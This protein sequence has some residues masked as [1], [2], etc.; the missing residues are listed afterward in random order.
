M[1]NEQKVPITIG[2]ITVD[3]P[4]DRRTWSGINN[5]LLRA[6]NERVE[7]VIPLGPLRP[8]PLLFL[9]K[10]INQVMLRTTGKRFNYRD[11]FLLSRAYARR[12]DRRLKGVDLLLAPA[13][14]ATTA[15][16]RTKVPVVYVN[17]RCIAGA[18][19]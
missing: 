7:R 19:D 3:D 10:L 5:F 18:L 15:M 6:L 14:L 17:D 13:G 4:H 9:L 16:L 12:I 1:A 2:Y 11:S 8:Q